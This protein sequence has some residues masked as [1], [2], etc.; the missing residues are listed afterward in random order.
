MIRR[1]PRSTLFPYTTLFRSM[2]KDA[3][4]RDCFRRK[5]TQEAVAA[6][7]RKSDIFFGPGALQS[8]REKWHELVEFLARED[9]IVL[10]FD[11]CQLLAH[12]V[13]RNSK[14]VSVFGTVVPDAC[15]AHRSDA[16]AKSVVQDL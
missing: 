11:A 4:G 16:R 8:G 7:D 1:P 14:G 13:N 12:R 9:W 15:N 10:Q 2:H 5:L 3:A 6:R